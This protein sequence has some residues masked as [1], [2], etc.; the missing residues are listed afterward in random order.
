MVAENKEKKSLQCLTLGSLISSAQRDFE[1]TRLPSTPELP[2]AHGARHKRCLTE[3]LPHTALRA[4]L[5]CALGFCFSIPARP[6]RRT[7]RGWLFLELMWE[8][9]D[10]IFVLLFPHTPSECSYY[11]ARY[12]FLL[13]ELLTLGGYSLKHKPH[14]PYAHRVLWML[15]H[16][17][18]EGAG[19]WLKNLCILILSA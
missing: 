11:E 6:A 10:Q 19:D 5:H 15:H 17:E 4:A 18:V 7:G 13:L 9:L 2:W 1:P 16:F 3:P 12:C 8:T 14:L